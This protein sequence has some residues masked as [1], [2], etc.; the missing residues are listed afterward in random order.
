[1]EMGGVFFWKTAVF[2]CNKTPIKMFLLF[3]FTNTSDLKL[4]QMLTWKKVK[5]KGGGVIKRIVNFPY[6]KDCSVLLANYP[7]DFRAQWEGRVGERE[8]VQFI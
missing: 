4:K 5:F 1:M 2:L 7:V 6:A 8:L 3:R